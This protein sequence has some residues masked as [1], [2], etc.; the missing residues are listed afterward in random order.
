MYSVLIVDDEQII[1]EGLTT[2]IDWNAV[3]Y[4]VAGTAANGMLAL[5]FIS[6]N[7]VDVVLADIKMPRM[8]GLE[9]SAELSNTYPDIF[10][11]ILSGY[12]N[13]EYA[14]KAI[15]NR[16]F[17]YLLK[18]C[19]EEEIIDVFSRLSQHISKERNK[20][21]LARTARRNIIREELAERLSENSSLP[22]TTQLTEWFQ[23]KSGSVFFAFHTRIITEKCCSAET[24]LFTDMVEASMPGKADSIC[25]R[26]NDNTFAILAAININFEY[27]P[28]IFFTI[29]KSAA[30]KYFKQEV[31]AGVSSA[32]YSIKNLHNKYSEAKSA[33][34][35]SIY[36]SGEELCKFNSKISSTEVSA[37]D[38]EILSKALLSMDRQ[39]LRKLFSAFFDEAET[40]LTGRTELI[41]IMSGF[42]LKTRII[43]SS[44]GFREGSI[45]GDISDFKNNTAAC[46]SLE[47]MKSRVFVLQDKWLANIKKYKTSLKSPLIEESLRIISNRYSED[48]CLDRIAEELQV[49]PNYFSRLFKKE[50]G[51]NFKDYLTDTRIN[52]A[53]KLLQSSQARVYEISDMVGYNDH[54][55]FSEVFKKTT[56]MSP[57]EFRRIAAGTNEIR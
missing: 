27:Q 33:E 39:G 35:I 48:I 1:R 36:C 32:F 55:Y 41:N 13:F 52:S 15:T 10:T 6:E 4:E 31:S 7:P 12:D 42:M 2:I 8:T 53:R 17:S 28:E 49:T 45:L 16:V 24:E 37:I 54:R 38:A 56:G 44:K 40:C 18:P 26:T 34:N 3:G 23:N 22:E 47:E 20:D 43:L 21:R 51:I 14:K 19:R 57:K 25:T 30:E 46:L 11:V 9:L 29:I 5:D 50:T